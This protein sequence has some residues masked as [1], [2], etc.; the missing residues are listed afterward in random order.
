MESEFMTAC[1]TAQES[2]WLLQLL[3]EFGC[4][5]PAP[6]S[7]HSDNKAMCL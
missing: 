4:R 6:F 3:K 7:I 5:F 2:L 1:A